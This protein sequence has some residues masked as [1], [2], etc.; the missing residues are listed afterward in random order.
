MV[1]GNKINLTKNSQLWDK[2]IQKENASSYKLILHYSIKNFSYCIFDTENNEFLGVKFENINNKKD[3]TSILESEIFTWDFQSVLISVQTIKSTIIPNSIYDEKIIEKYLYFD[4]E[5][6]RQEI[7]ASN[8]FL[9]YIDASVVFSLDKDLKLILDNKFKKIHL[10]SQASI[11]I[12]S[13]LRKSAQSKENLVFIDFSNNYFEIGLV[14]QSKLFLYNKF[15]FN[16][17]EDFLYYILN[18]FNTSNLDSK[19]DK[20]YISGEFQKNEVIN[21]LKEYLN[22]IYLAKRDNLYSY[23]N[24]LNTIPEFYFHKLYNIIKCV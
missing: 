9:K 14:K 15:N 8:D 7:I 19:K 1:I 23:S 21:P 20:I 5:I 2:R 3:L 12:D 6:N 10:K 17:K 11:F 22:F 16:T 18:C 13:I 24:A 4:E